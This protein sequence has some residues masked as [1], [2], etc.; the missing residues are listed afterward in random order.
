MKPEIL[1]LFF[2]HFGI[3]GMRNVRRQLCRENVS[4]ARWT[5]ARLMLDIGL[6]EGG[7][8]N[9]S[10]PRSAT[11]AHPIHSTALIAVQS[12]GCGCRM[13]GLARGWPPCVPPCGRRPRCP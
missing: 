5:V 11:R 8:A 9:R 4:A 13:Q 7:A 12:T 1:R 2:K 3:Y 10:E 6:R